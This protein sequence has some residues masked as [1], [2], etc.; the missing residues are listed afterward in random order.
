MLVPPFLPPLPR[1]PPFLFPPSFPPPHSSVRR[2]QPHDI[3]KIAP[4]SHTFRQQQPGR[5]LACRQGLLLLLL[6]LAPQWRRGI[7]ASL[8][9]LPSAGTTSPLMPSCTLTRHLLSRGGQMGARCLLAC[10]LPPGRR[11]GEAACDAL[12][13]AFGLRNQRLEAAYPMQT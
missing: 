4:A 1:S 9:S 6:L 2:C 3:L 10:V 8:L 5:P 11:G 13:A 12:A 7:D